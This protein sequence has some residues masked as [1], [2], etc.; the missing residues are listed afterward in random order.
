MND[1]KDNNLKLRK[2]L[3]KDLGEE[4]VFNQMLDSG[5]PH[6]SKVNTPEERRKM[7]NSC[8]STKNTT[9]KKLRDKINNELGKPINIELQCAP[10]D[11]PSEEEIAN[12]SSKFIEKYSTNI[13]NLSDRIDDTNNQKDQNFDIDKWTNK[14]E[15]IKN[16]ANN[17]IKENNMNSKKTFKERE[18]ILEKVAKEVFDK[19]D[20]NEKVE[21]PTKE[22]VKADR[23][24]Y[25]KNRELD[26]EEIRKVAETIVSP[27][28]S[29]SG[30]TTHSRP[31]INTFTDNEK[32]KDYSVNALNLINSLVEHHKKSILIK[33]EEIDYL[34]EENALLRKRMSTL[35]NTSSQYEDIVENL[36]VDANIPKERN[37]EQS[38]SEIA[39]TDLFVTKNTFLEN[40]R[41][42]RLEKS[43]LAVNGANPSAIKR[44]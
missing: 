39:L 5:K 44:T 11:F 10:E 21:F 3:L 25:N 35:Q 23:K 40:D 15:E 20:K 31:S 36:V 22:E 37:E 13:L 38:N 28:T 16:I 8:K 17:K 29:Y 6:R 18:E 1:K 33:M 26:I 4:E 43:Q 42:N 2:K 32:F 27:L 19:L 12:E 30:L 24:I 9:I 41:Q 7:F 34:K 14:I